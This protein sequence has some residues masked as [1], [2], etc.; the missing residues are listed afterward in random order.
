MVSCRLP[1]SQSNDHPMI[2]KT[3]ASVP[4]DHPM[5]QVPKKSFRQFSDLQ[6]VFQEIQVPRCSTRCCSV[7][8]TS[9]TRKEPNS[10][11][12]Y[13]HQLSMIS[14]TNGWLLRLWFLPLPSHKRWNYRLGCG[15]PAGPWFFQTSKWLMWVV[16]PRF[17]SSPFMVAIWSNSYTEQINFTSSNTVYSNMV[18]ICNNGLQPEVKATPQ[19]VAFQHEGFTPKSWL[20]D[21]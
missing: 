11:C 2:R 1:L 17:V 21:D 18:I 7:L 19:K 20:S 10:Y 5:S 8:V 15:H 4:N 3:P 6:R 16:Q 12:S 14:G 9:F 13:V